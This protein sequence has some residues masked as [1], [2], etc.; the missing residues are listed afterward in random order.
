MVFWDGEQPPKIV[1]FNSISSNICSKYK[2]HP[3]PLLFLESD[4]FD[5]RQ[6]CLKNVVFY[7]YGNNINRLLV[8]HCYETRIRRVGNLVVPHMNKTTQ[9]AS[10]SLFKT[11]VSTYLNKLTEIAYIN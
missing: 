2:R 10:L 6:L 3:S 5:P 9:H 1:F 4:L 8:C 7:E 11:G